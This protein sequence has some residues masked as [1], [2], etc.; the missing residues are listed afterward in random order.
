MLLLQAE[1]QLPASSRTHLSP[2]PL[3]SGFASEL[4]SSRRQALTLPAGPLAPAHLAPSVKLETMLP[5]LPT[6]V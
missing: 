3:L 5:L 4:L 2:S 6:L 1:V